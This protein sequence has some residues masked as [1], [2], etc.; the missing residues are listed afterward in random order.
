[1][2]IEFYF[3]NAWLCRSSSDNIQR[4]IGGGLRVGAV[5][6]NKVTSSHYDFPFEHAPRRRA[7]E[8]RYDDG[9]D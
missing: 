7:A 9:Q 2:T 1:M 4:S 3:K 6:G 5:R 8:L